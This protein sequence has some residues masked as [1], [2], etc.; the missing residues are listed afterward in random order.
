MFSVRESTNIGLHAP[1]D[2]HC[3]V[4]KPQ[5]GTQEEERQKLE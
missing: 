2:T 4:S 3:T 5:A 1:L